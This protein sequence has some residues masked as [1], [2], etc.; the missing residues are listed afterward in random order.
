MTS[1]SLLWKRPAGPVGEAGLEPPC[2][3]RVLRSRNHFSPTVAE[4]RPKAKKV[5]LSQNYPD[6][7]IV[8]E[9][10]GL[11]LDNRIA[12]LETRYIGEASSVTAPGAY[13]HCLSEAEN[14]ADYSRLTTGTSLKRK[15]EVDDCQS[16]NL[17]S[18]RQ[19][20]LLRPTSPP[21][22]DSAIQST[23]VRASE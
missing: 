12:Y 9:C 23:K 11:I 1:G 2:K 19:C 4:D 21:F 8:S 16:H 22:S 18:K 5:R 10:R 14:I 3:I 7:P 13:D 6:H 20:S 17:N 15:I